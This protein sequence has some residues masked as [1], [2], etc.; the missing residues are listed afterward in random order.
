L[1]NGPGGKRTEGEKGGKRRRG[2][3]LLRSGEDVGKKSAGT[4]RFVFVPQAVSGQGDELRRI[5][6][7]GPDLYAVEVAGADYFESFERH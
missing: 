6:V 1:D 4:W 2:S 7:Y 3:D 5:F